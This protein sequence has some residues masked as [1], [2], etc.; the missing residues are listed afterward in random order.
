ME[1]VKRQKDQVQEVAITLFF[2]FLKYLRFRVSVVKWSVYVSKNY[3]LLNFVS[4]F[5]KKDTRLYLEESR[6]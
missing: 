1:T 2:F 4:N 6:T 5:G 3:C